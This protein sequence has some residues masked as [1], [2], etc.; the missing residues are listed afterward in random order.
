MV[1]GDVLRFTVWGSNLGEYWQTHFDYRVTLI[2]SAPDFQPFSL[3]SDWF[4]LEFAT[5]F[6]PTVD[7]YISNNVSYQG[8]K[9]ENL[10]NDGQIGE[11]LAASLGLGLENDAALAPEICYKLKQPSGRR[12]MNPGFKSIPGVTIASVA[13]GGGIGAGA[14]TA[15]TAFAAECSSDQSV[16]TADDIFEFDM[17]PIVVGNFREGSGTPNSPYKYRLPAT[18]A[19]LGS[20]WY[21]AKNW[22][23][24]PISS[25]MNS[26][27][28]GR[29]K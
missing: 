21:Y 27:K 17:S 13:D 12:G 9:A 29:G 20:R 25:T 3:V 24:L 22:T 26:R 2:E 11:T 1:V 23:V 18:Q 6:W 16:L 4:A 15:F 14:T 10:F 7:D 19:E 28:Y 5:N 8:F